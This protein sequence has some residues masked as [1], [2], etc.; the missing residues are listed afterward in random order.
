[1]ET[2]VGQLQEGTIGTVGE[3]LFSLAQLLP[4]RLGYIK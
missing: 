1:M 4:R 2:C 3:T